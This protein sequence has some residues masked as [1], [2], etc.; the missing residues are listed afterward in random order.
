MALWKWCG[1]KMVKLLR[2]LLRKPLIQGNY[3]LCSF[4]KLVE[5]AEQKKIHQKLRMRVY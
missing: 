4:P 2:I 3:F 1:K 5:Q